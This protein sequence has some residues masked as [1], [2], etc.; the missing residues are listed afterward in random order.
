MQINESRCPHYFSFILFEH[1]L[2]S[3]IS[4]RFSWSLIWTACYCLL[5]IYFIDQMIGTAKL[6]Y[7]KVNKYTIMYENAYIV[8]NALYSYT[9]KPV[10]SERHARPLTVWQ[11][12]LT[13]LCKI[14]HTSARTKVAHATWYIGAR[15]L[16]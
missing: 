15:N 4:Q 14:Q 10:E 3:S 9:R 8:E 11:P 1:H 7:V 6:W 5:E 13:S 16:I 2:I 12:N